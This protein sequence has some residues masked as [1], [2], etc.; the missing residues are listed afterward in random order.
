MKLLNEY[1]VL[2]KFWLAL[3]QT[4]LMLLPGGNN[5]SKLFSHA[6]QSVDGVDHVMTNVI[7]WKQW[8]VIGNLGLRG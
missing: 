7:F 1:T 5:I 3:E 8:P 2:H 6:T 4:V